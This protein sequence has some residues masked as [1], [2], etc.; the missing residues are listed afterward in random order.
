MFSVL[1]VNSS[2][3]AATTP[4][5]NMIYVASSGS[6][7]GSGSASSPYKTIQYAIDK[8][9]AGTTIYVSNGT[10][11]QKLKIS[12]KKDI[13]IVS[14]PG[15]APV[16]TGAGFSS[17]NLITIS[18]SSGIKFSGFDI[19]NYWSATGFE[20]IYVNTGCS[21]IEISNNTIHDL[22]TTSSGGNVHGILVKSY[23]S[24]VIT[25]VVIKNN[26]LFNLKTGWSESITVQ[27]N[28]DGFW[29]TGNILHNNTNIGIDIAGFYGSTTI[30]AS[31][32]QARHGY[33]QGNMIYDL[34][35]SYAT[36]AG[37]YVDGGRDTII[38]NNT[39]RNTMV[40][41][42]VGCENATDRT[43]GTPAIVSNITVQK[44]IVYN[45]TSEAIGVGGYDGLNTG[46]I[47]NTKV[48]NNTLYN[49]KRGVEFMYADS[50]EIGR[51]IIYNLT[52]DKYF[53]YDSLKM[54]TNVNIH[55]NFYF[56]DSGTGKWKFSGIYAYSLSEWIAKLHYDMTARFADP[57]FVDKANGDFRLKAGSP[58]TGYGAK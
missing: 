42:E 57:L 39:L 29:V 47:I 58:A 6:D 13:S 26:K 16:I 17:G 7:S 25:N 43:T 8:A 3:S 54:A 20:T 35:C 36:C 38:E 33:V 2:V 31:L 51:N 5:T 50:I 18:S 22:G 46:K 1:F 4:M 21:N 49:N 27:G 32:N 11:N 44:N 56:V 19:T 9:A 48:L 10:Y 30:P 28:V 37:I 14:S 45:S 24:A 40:G 41:I 23:S 12:N 52:S 53:I 55:D 15:N 34:Y